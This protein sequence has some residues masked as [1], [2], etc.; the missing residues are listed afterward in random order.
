MKTILKLMTV[1]L[2]VWGILSLRQTAQTL[3]ALEQGIIRLHILADSDTIE[4][5]TNKLMVRDALLEASAG[6][7]DGCADADDCLAVLKQ[8]LPQIERTASETLRGNGSRDTVTAA[9]ETTAFPARK[10]GRI[11]LP[12]GRYRALTVR[13]GRGEG[14]NWWCVMY[15]ALCL[16]AASGE[17]EPGLLAET[18]PEAVCDMTEAPERYEIRLKCV[19]VCRSVADWIQRKFR[20]A[21]QDPAASPTD[22]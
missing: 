10:Y 12:A 16:P 8:K 21:E 11:T 4:S 13:I 17:A 6:W 15:P 5:Q 7:F 2:A 1:L 14:Q 22:A 9:L 19:D 18:L 3:G 20:G